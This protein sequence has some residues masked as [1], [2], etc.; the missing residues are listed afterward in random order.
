[1]QINTAVEITAVFHLNEGSAKL[2]Q[3]R[4]YL[5]EL[6][7][8]AFTTAATRERLLHSVDEPTKTP[9]LP[10]NQVQR[11]ICAAN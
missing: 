2:S 5:V 6:L 3:Y 1:M 8:P 9:D 11:V 7:L 10:R 4:N